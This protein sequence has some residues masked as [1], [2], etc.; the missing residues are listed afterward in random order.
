MD[1]RI[2]EFPFLKGLLSYYF[3]SRDSI[4]EMEKRRFFF[5]F[6]PIQFSTKGG[7]NF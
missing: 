5:Y 6:T 4:I 1:Y 7:K 2:I 3:I